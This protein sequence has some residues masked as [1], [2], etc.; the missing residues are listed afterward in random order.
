ME[1]QQKRTFLKSVMAACA[2]VA[3][4]GGNVTFAQRSRL[5]KI[6][7]TLETLK[8]FDPHEGVNLF[9]DFSEAIF[10]NPSKGHARAWDALVMG[11]PGR[12]TRELLIRICLAISEANEERSLADQIEIVTLCNRLGIKPEK[13]GLYVD[14]PEFNNALTPDIHQE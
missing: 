12:E 4:A 1:R 8:V 3:S 5:D 6:L 7:E 14:D 2:M 10:E 11:A 13:C 9:N